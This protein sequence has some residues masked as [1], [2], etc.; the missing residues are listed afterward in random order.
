MKRGARFATILVIMSCG[1]GGAQAMSLKEA[2]QLTVNTHPSIAAARADRR[3]T[4]YELRQAQGRYLPT[5]DLSADVGEQLIDR[6]NGL[7]A[8]T[9][10]KWLTRR[11]AGVAVRQVLFDGFDRANDVYKN[12]ARIDSSAWRVLERSQVLGLSAVEAYIDVRRHTDLVQIAQDNVRRHQEILRRVNARR[13]GGKASSGE[14]DQTSERV[15]AARAVVAEIEQ[16][17]QE[18]VARFRQVVGRAPGSTNPVRTPRGLPATRSIAV[19]VGTVENPTVKA[20]ASDI[21]VARFERE[22]SASGY[23]PTIALEG[24][25]SAGH[26]LNGTLGRDQEVVGKVT[27]SWNIFDGLIT[28]N[29]RRALAEREAQ[30]FAEHD[31]RVRETAEAIE[32]AWAA[33]T[34]GRVRVDSFR[35][36][37][38][39][40][41]KVVASY[42]EEYELSKRTLLDLLDSENA[43]FNSRFQLSSINAVHLFSAY[44]LLASMGRLLDTLG[45]AAPAEAVADHRLQSQKTFGV[46]NIEI[47]PLRKQ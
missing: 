12:A 40:N 15:E 45:V 29:R 2:V 36:Q 28:T 5:V 10:N 9:N 22:R 13:E 17:R 42:L 3:A 8:A 14:V 26:D 34:Q 24:T 41:R 38:E 43:L 35:Q 46:F 25:A 32:R 30:A 7:S 16:A 18:S 6:P 11:Q 1:S 33:Y 4:G 37:V 44:Q 23:F 31:A 19:H 21:D 47:E 20:A 39:L 27:A